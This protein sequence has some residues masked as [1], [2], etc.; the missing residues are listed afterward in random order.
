[1]RYMTLIS[2]NFL[3]LRQPSNLSAD[4][5]HMTFVLGWNEAYWFLN[6]TYQMSSY[7][8]TY[9]IP[10][11]TR[12]TVH[13][14]FHWIVSHT[15][16]FKDRCLSVVCIM[17]S[18]SKINDGHL[19]AAIEMTFVSTYDWLNLA[20]VFE[21]KTLDGKSCKFEIEYY[22]DLMF[23][24]GTQLLVLA[25][26]FLVNSPQWSEILGSRSKS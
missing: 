19:N 15:A 5:I 2:P 22:V 4:N 16:I 8:V 12:Q 25:I 17:A 6:H 14:Q 1:M 11:C 21:F 13:R 24:V 9:G 7:P 23:T 3:R 10:L 26:I 20:L 18:Q